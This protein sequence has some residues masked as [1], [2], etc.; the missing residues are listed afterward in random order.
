MSGAP[1]VRAIN[2]ADS[3]ARPVLGPAGNGNKTGSLIA[4]KPGAKP[5]RQVEK[6]AGEQLAA[7][8]NAHKAS[9]VTISPKL[10]SVNVPSVLRRHE[11]FLHSNLSLNASCSSDAST[12]SF[13]SRASTGR[14]TRSNSVG[15]R[16]KPCASKPRS[17]TSDGSLESTPDGLQTKKRCAW[18]TS[19]AGGF[20]LLWSWRNSS[21]FQMVTVL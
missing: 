7:D 17:V 14:L 1:R 12:D 18:L 16:R 10:R 2:V 8:N 3:E 13:H 9:M 15:S 5:M 20:F 21:I 4:R 11:Q 6:S 19:N